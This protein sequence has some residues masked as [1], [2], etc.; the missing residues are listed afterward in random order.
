[1]LYPHFTDRIVPGWLDKALPWRR[2]RGHW[3]DGVVLASPSRKYLSTLPFGKLPDRGD[4]KRFENDFAGRL[5]YWRMAIAQ[6]ERLGDEFL[7]FAERPDASR[8]AAL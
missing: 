2:A 8:L 5:G 7:A 4:F 3:L 6:I 1:M